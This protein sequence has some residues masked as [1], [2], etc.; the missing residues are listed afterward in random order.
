[1]DNF[2]ILLICV[3]C[4]SIYT[5]F[6]KKKAGM[7]PARWPRPGVPEDFIPTH[8]HDNVALDAKTKRL[9][10]REESGR[11]QLFE[12]GDITGWSATNSTNTNAYGKSWPANVYLEIKT[13]SVDKPL[14][15]ARFK[16]YGEKTPEQRN[17]NDCQEWFER[18]NAVYNHS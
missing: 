10:V 1:M 8:A 15:R 9:W 7:G 14:W 3:I 17:Y 13:T 18:L 12:A 6:F 11:E 4:W 2:L 16:H 5:L